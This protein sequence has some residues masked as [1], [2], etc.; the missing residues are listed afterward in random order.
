MGLINEQQKKNADVGTSPIDI[1]VAKPPAPTTPAIEA[2]PTPEYDNPIQQAPIEA[3][4][5]RVRE[6]VEE[7]AG[8][9]ANAIGD[10]TKYNDIQ[11]E[12]AEPKLPAPV[13]P[14]IPSL[15]L[16]EDTT[17]DIEKY[18][19]ADPRTVANK[20]PTLFGQPLQQPANIAGQQANQL[21]TDVANRYTIDEQTR[22]R[23]QAI[24]LQ[25][26]QLA[27]KRSLP[28]T[29]DIEK[30]WH[31]QAWAGL[32]G[33]ID[34]LLFGTPGARANTSNGKA[35]FNVQAGAYG[36]HGAGLGGLLKYAL[37][38]PLGLANTIGA[39]F[40]ELSLQERQKAYEFGNPIVEYR[41]NKVRYKL[42]TPE[43][44]REVA[45][46]ANNK[47]F[48]GVFPAYNYK[49]AE[50]NFAKQYLEIITAKRV[51]DDLNDANPNLPPLPGAKPEPPKGNFFDYSR[52][53]GQPWYQSKGSGWEVANQ[54]FSPG[55]KID[56]V[57]NVIGAAV[58]KGFGT[59]TDILFGNWKQAQRF[60]KEAAEFY[61]NIAKREE[62]ASLVNRALPELTVPKP[63]EPDLSQPLPAL[64]RPLATPPNALPDVAPPRGEVNLPEFNV[65]PPR[66]LEPPVVNPLPASTPLEPV[67]LPAV[68]KGF[69]VSAP[70]EFEI[71]P[72]VPD[73]LNV[74][75]PV[76]PKTDASTVV[77]QVGNLKPGRTIEFVPYVLPRNHDD[78]V[79]F[80]RTGTEE[81]QAFVKNYTGKT[82]EDWEEFVAAS[83]KNNGQFGATGKLPVL[84]PSIPK[85]DDLVK[86]STDLAAQKDLIEQATEQLD[87][88]FDATID[89]GR[90]AIDELPKGRTTVEAVVKALDLGAKPQLT[91]EAVEA[92]PAQVKQAF[93][94][95][96]VTKLDELTDSGALTPEII[97][98]VVAIN[99]KSLEP[100]QLV[101]EYA[102]KSLST[103][104]PKEVYHGT[105]LA[106]WT[107]NFN[108]KE[109]GSRGELGSGIYTTKDLAEAT[110]Y[111]RAFVG[112]NVNSNA[113]YAPL[114]PNVT[115]LDTSAFKATLDA[116][117]R[118]PAA[119]IEAV[120]A[121]VPGF[122]PP[123]KQLSYKSLVSAL[124]RS[125]ALTD[126]SEKGLQSASSVLSDALRATGYDSV[127][128]R[129]SGWFVALDNGKLAVKRVDP[130]SAP[131][132]PLEA[133]IARYNV[134][135]RAA[136]NYDKH[137][138]SASNL[139]DSTYKL[140]EQTK[141]D[142]DEAL[143]DVQ[144]RAIEAIAKQKPVSMAPVKKSVVAKSVRSK[145]ATKTVETAVEQI[146]TFGRTLDVPA[147]VRAKDGSL[148]VVANQ[149]AL[150]AARTA[151]LPEIDVQINGVFE[152]LLTDELAAAR[153]APKLKYAPK[154]V[155]AALEEL[156][157]TGSLTHLPVYN[158]TTDGTLFPINKTDV[159]AKAASRYNK[160][161]KSVIVENGQ[162]KLQDILNQRDV[163][164]QPRAPR[165]PSL[166][167]LA[168]LEEDIGKL[169]PAHTPK[170]KRTSEPIGKL[171]V[172]TASEMSEDELFKQLDV[173]NRRLEKL[174]NGDFDMKSKLDPESQLLRA[175][176]KVTE[177]IEALRSKQTQVEP[178]S[179]K[180]P[181]PEPTSVKP[182]EV[183]EMQSL[184]NAIKTTIGGEI[185]EVKYPWLS[186][187]I[188]ELPNAKLYLAS[189]NKRTPANAI[190]QIYNSI[191]DLGFDGRELLNEFGEDT[192]TII[193][194]GARTTLEDLRATFPNLQRT[195]FDKVI[196]ELVYEDGYGRAI[197]WKKAVP[198]SALTPAQL[199]S[200]I[201]DGKGNYLFEL[202]P[203]GREFENPYKSKV[204]PEPVATEAVDV[205]EPEPNWDD[206][207]SKAFEG[208][209]D[210]LIKYGLADA[211]N[212]E[213]NVANIYAKA[214]PANNIP[215]SKVAEAANRIE[216]AITKDLE[217]FSDLRAKLSDLSR[218]EFDAG[219]YKLEADG[220][221]VVNTLQEASQFSAKANRDAIPQY[222]GGSL[223]YLTK[224]NSDELLSSFKAPVNPKESVKELFDELEP[225][226]NC[227]Y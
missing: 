139:A 156:E 107:P 98:D 192:V 85:L 96:D 226:T 55:N 141:A 147:L 69:D 131:Q 66:L 39:N 213:S 132:N 14:N 225:P 99:N 26:A 114:S 120:K 184:A 170:A 24:S 214:F 223:F 113:R 151:K 31:E 4:E 53:P 61:A 103:V 35:Q 15:N 81:Q 161:V 222:A 72:V 54:L 82:W 191:Y 44:K 17:P 144:A 160:P 208:D 8:D 169:F 164:L 23:N 46:E 91:N 73:N 157:S 47:L 199:E 178:T 166:K 198:E 112:E 153:V 104:V 102:T 196:D 136:K 18:G 167:E 188:D 130:V 58:G 206:L 224:E 12:S 128:D 124:E 207:Y 142:V 28:N 6:E 57:G 16:W 11:G 150:E 100:Q 177:A 84:E 108:V 194:T 71:K 32:P 168:E 5:M 101:T 48:G 133:A 95:N 111:A 2:E 135:T 97:E 148:T 182:P 152:T 190:A 215:P 212:P 88:L 121:R 134:D 43:A 119:V 60:K 195:E 203:T 175:E 159:L 75:T 92:L 118:L 204:E 30:P 146:N 3:F 219:V 110:E 38:T 145:A 65:Q 77:S 216:Q 34:Q 22:Q 25:E 80:L 59:T 129:K 106:D 115:V 117:K 13:A 9:P 193:A 202:E 27:R 1:P 51:G 116:S 70:R 189:S 52:R 68:L 200:A 210:T 76:L 143:Q 56:V 50:R 211:N 127:Y 227:S 94:E 171:K 173:A 7:N 45:G 162:A 179:V 78:L 154:T 181:E 140:L 87:E 63:P 122:T 163:V 172:K 165:E 105:A 218:A 21:F 20:L 201:P 138:T 93:L 10:F 19:A 185:D 209:E 155:K 158:R 86:Q 149:H 186:Q 221:V 205:Q 187:A 125:T 109:F 33:F 49:Y 83:S 62:A 137:V 89:V 217:N 126:S 36:V 90:R 64:E 183:D 37:S 41:G 42:L 67:R 79:K 74:A 29:P 197:K 40:S 176:R 174:K 220:I 123:G 180:A